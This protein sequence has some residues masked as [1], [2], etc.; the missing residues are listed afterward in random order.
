MDQELKKRKRNGISDFRII[1]V[2]VISK[3]MG[4]D[5][6]TQDYMSEKRLL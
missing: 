6:T 2:W 5:T 3:V 1:S 4:I